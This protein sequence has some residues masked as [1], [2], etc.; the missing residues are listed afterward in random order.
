MF[1]PSI[2]D[3]YNLASCYLACIISR[4]NSNITRVELQALFC[5]NIGR[6]S[7]AVHLEPLI[8]TRLSGFSLVRLAVFFLALCALHL[9]DHEV[10]RYKYDI[11]AVRL[12]DYGFGAGLEE[13]G[14]FEQHNR[15]AFLNRATF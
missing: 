1:L 5:N 8:T 14:I 12:G 9:F 2:N 7:G 15:R 11:I 4:F 10:V 6:Y 3:V 13:S